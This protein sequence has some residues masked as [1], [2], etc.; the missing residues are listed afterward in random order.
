MGIRI[1]QIYNDG[2]PVASMTELVLERDLVGNPVWL[3]TTHQNVFP[4]VYYA[5]PKGFG[6]TALSRW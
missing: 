3:R 6:S 2:D 4:R 5:I 1:I